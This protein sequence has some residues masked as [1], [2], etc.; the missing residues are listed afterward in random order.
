M[1]YLS[2]VQNIHVQFFSPSRYHSTVS[3]LSSIDAPL[4]RLNIL[5]SR[6]LLLGVVT[7]L[8]NTVAEELVHKTFSRF[9]SFD[10][11]VISVFF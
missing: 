5:G 8:F 10:V 7:V 3:V 1:V 6:D 2:V 11:Q 9:F 4:G